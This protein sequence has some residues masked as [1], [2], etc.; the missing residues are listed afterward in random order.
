MNV[1][2]RLLIE[3]IPGAI[4]LAVNAI[5]GLFPATAAALCGTLLAICLRYQ[6]DGQLPYLALATVVLSVTLFYVS[7]ILDDE[8]FIKIRSTISGIAFAAMLFIGSLFKPSLLERSLGYKLLILQPGWR[9]MHFSWGSLALVFALLNEL[10]WRSSSTD[11]WV[12]YSTVVGPIAFG[13]YWS[14]TWIVC[15]YYWDELEDQD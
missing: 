11:V 15:W 1:D 13:F 10:V 7:I 9:A 14:A 12:L 6:I 2:R 3:L 8:D 4:F 5:W